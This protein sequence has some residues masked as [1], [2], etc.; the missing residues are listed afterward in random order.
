MTARQISIGLLWHSDRSGNLGVGAL[1][2]GNI[3]IVRKVAA[4]LDIVPNFV[5]MGFN[6]NNRPYIEEADIRFA[7]LGLSSAARF[8]GQVGSMDCILDI[9]GGDSFTDIYPFKRYAWIIASKLIAIGR[10]VPLVFA[11]QTIGPF[12]GET[13]AK[14]SLNQL[15]RWSMRRARAVVV[16]DMRSAETVRAL[17]PGVDPV[18]AVDVAFALTWTAPL[19]SV[20]APRI[21]INVSGLLWHGGH[22]GKGEFKLGYDYRALMTGLIETLVA[23]GDVTV[24]LICHVNGEPGSNEDDGAVADA[25]AAQY[26]SLIRVPDFASPSAAKSHIAGLDALVAARM[27]AC[28]AAFSS[29][30]PVVPVSYSRK[31]EGLFGSLGYDRLVPFTGMGTDAALAFILAALDQRAILAT[32]ITAGLTRVEARLDAYRDVLRTLFRSLGKG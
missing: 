15:A 19:P 3:A 23:R 12:L 13:A 6:D 20:G 18:Y 10:R 4:E 7:P 1:T 31:F 16:R 14:R 32:E 17:V 2:V 8:A 9:G 21:G 5:I 27:H 29:G 28:I 25:L 22:T 26:P 24:E 30:V 11:P